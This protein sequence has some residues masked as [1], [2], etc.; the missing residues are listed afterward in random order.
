MSSK[1]NIKKILPYLRSLGISPETLGPNKLK[2]LLDFTDNIK[3]PSE[4]SNS[5]IS[6][7]IEIMGVELQSKKKN[8]KVS[9]RIGRNEKCICESGKKWKNCCGKN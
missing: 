6:K 1:T 9:I 3:D 4:I 2:K 8:P 7:I 5:D